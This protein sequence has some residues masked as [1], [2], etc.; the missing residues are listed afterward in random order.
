V[1]SEQLGARLFR[2]ADG[3]H[4]GPC[5]GLLRLLPLVPET[6]GAAQLPVPLAAG[7]DASVGHAA[8][9][10]P[11]TSLAHAQP[12]Q[13]DGRQATADGGRALRHDHLGGA[14]PHAAG[15]LRNCQQPGHPAC[16]TPLQTHRGELLLLFRPAIQV[17]FVLVRR[18]GGGGVFPEICLT[19]ALTI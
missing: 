15:C 8:V 17:N 16:Q 1:E 10:A 2:R 5:G 9:A 13:D 12:R 19:P 18:E 11:T 7:P 3:G 4:G 14:L 6:L